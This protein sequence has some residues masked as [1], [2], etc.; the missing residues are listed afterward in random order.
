MVKKMMINAL[1][2][3]ECRVAVVANGQLEE[4]YSETASHEQ[5]RGNVYKA[6]VE[7][8]EPSLQAAFVNYGAAKNGFLQIGE[9]H[10][11]Y[12]PETAKGNPPPID[13]IFRRGQEVLVQVTKEPT[14]NKGAALT[15]YISLAG[16]NLVLMPG[17]DGGGVSRKVEDDKERSRLKKILS[18]MDVP[19]HLGVII[20]TRAVGKSKAALNRDLAAIIRVWED[21]RD[22]LP[23]APSPSL[24]YKDE[25]LAL[26]IIRD[27][28]NSD[29]SEV[30]IDN[31]DLHTRIQ[32]Y[33]KVVAPKSASKVKLY[34]EK[35]PIF[36]K[37]ELERQI[38]SI[39]S[40]SVSLPSG[41]AIV[42]EATEALVA[43]DVNSGKAT[44]ARDIEITAYKTNLEAA[45]EAARQLRMRDM[46]GL[47]VVDFIDMREAKHNRGVVKAFRDEA[48]KDKARIR[49]GAISRFGLLE[50]SRQRIRPSIETG[51]YVACHHCEGRGVVRS[52]ESAALGW[53][54]RI[55][56][57]VIAGQV[58][59]CRAELPLAVATYLLNFKREELY[60][61]ERR[62]KVR[63]VVTGRKELGPEEG[64]ISLLKADEVEGN[65]A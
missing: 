2:P 15:T 18:S 65:G 29:I 45:V 5:L 9:V 23:A 55:W 54:R 36:A 37:Y 38:D 28:F 33:L 25:V 6:F 61:L 53:L 34:K 51:T 56:H 20:R 3:E 22:G 39:Y 48:K 4:F 24:V 59:E 64:E 60:N 1:D 10:P 46:G 63:I 13:R 30:L 21:M 11:E 26:R 40:S 50:L 49:L 17:R 35:R 62:Y 7:N 42:I 44:K 43:I 19:D 31:S 41:G 27:H 58:A 12:W 52:T 8:V 14:G 16:V 47:I 57:G 32:D